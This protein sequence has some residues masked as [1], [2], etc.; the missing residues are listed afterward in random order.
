[1]GQDAEA[2][3]NEPAEDASQAIPAAARGR[4]GDAIAMQRWRRWMA[5]KRLRSVSGALRDGLERF[6]E[7]AKGTK[8]A[9]QPPVSVPCSFACFVG[10][11]DSV[12]AGDLAVWHVRLTVGPA[13]VIAGRVRSGTGSAQTEA[14]LLL[15]GA[16]HGYD[17]ALRP[18]MVIGHRSSGDV[19]WWDGVMSSEPLTGEGD[20]PSAALDS[21]D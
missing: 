18:R 20:D 8:G 9:K 14:Q 19:A 3:A 21:R 12:V 4:Q 15:C 7:T 2:A 17:G 6:R 13:Q 10:F 16:V 11:V 5:T 1:M